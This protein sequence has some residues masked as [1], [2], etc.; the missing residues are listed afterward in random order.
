MG[1]VCIEICVSLEIKASQHTEPKRETFNLLMLQKREKKMRLVHVFMYYLL[2][3]H[4]AVVSR[5]SLVDMWDNPT[6]DYLAGDI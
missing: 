4:S 3:H 1:Y 5:I 6:L 2:E